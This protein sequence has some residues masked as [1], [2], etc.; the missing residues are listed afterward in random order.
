MKKETDSKIR[1]KMKKIV[2]LG[3]ILFFAFILLY[4]Q[5]VFA[6]FNSNK[7]SNKFINEEVARQL[8]KTPNDLTSK[9]YQRIEE[10]HLTGYRITNL[11]LVKK[12]RNL[13]EISLWYTR[14]AVLKPLEKLSKLKILRIYFVGS[15]NEPSKI[16]KKLRSL[17]R[18]PEQKST[19][20]IIS[21]SPLK[22]LVN[23][24]KLIIRKMNIN[25]I[26]VLSGLKNLKELEITGIDISDITPLS[27]LTSLK[28][29]K[30]E[31]NR[32]ITDFDPLK[33]LVNLEALYITSVPISD[34]NFFT[35]F[36]NLKSLT[37]Y[38][39]YIKDISPLHKLPNLRTLSLRQLPIRD[40]SQFTKFTNLESLSL[41]SM[42]ISDI[43]PLVE[44]QNLRTLALV[45]LKVNDISPL[46][47]LKNL[48]HL[49]FWQQSM[50][51]EQIS[52]LKKALPNLEIILQPV[53]KEMDSI[54]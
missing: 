52:E 4:M 18:L 45:D 9:D 8:N 38:N 25:N 17:L 12:C 36:T 13:Q 28:V 20:K 54:F 42:Q 41:E 3:L 24:E 44:L 43:S 30:I 46:A 35:D 19:E 15:S 23:L 26:K 53:H 14:T 21:L 22:K 32:H 34:A 27:G 5:Y 50:D 7:E 33:K 16:M 49:N 37:L 47:D 51:N 11:N 10:L 39:K 31:G 1:Y 6:Y 29:L 40:P 48:K 2:Y